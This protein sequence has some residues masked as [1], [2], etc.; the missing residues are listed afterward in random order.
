MQGPLSEMTMEGAHAGVLG[1][2]K[3]LCTRHL[4]HVVS[5]D[6]ELDP[7]RQ[8]QPGPIL[9][10][11]IRSAI[12]NSVSTRQSGTKTV[13]GICTALAHSTGQTM[14]VNY[15]LVR[16]PPCRTE[17]GCHTQGVPWLV[18]IVSVLCRNEHAN[19]LFR[20][21][22]RPST[23]SIICKCLRRTR[24]RFT[25]QMARMGA[26]PASVDSTPDATYC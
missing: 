3:F 18:L 20:W 22:I 13:C 9:Q 26:M 7:M 24:T 25:C 1:Q 19:C 4:H 10:Q 15:T 2:T 17:S 14:H 21:S 8:S 12:R 5:F 6:A 23:V 16:A 11:T